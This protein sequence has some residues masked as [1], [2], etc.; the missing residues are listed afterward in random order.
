[1]N[2]FGILF[3]KGWAQRIII[4]G[5]IILYLYLG[6][7]K[8]E[9]AKK[10]ITGAGKTFASL[11]TLIFAALLISRAI[12]LLLPMETVMEWFGEDTG[13]KG[14]IRGGLLGGVLQGGPYAV[15][16][17]I[18]SIADKGAHISVVMAML[19]GYGAIGLARVAYGLVFF[20]AKIVGL[21]LLLAIPVPIVAGILV[22][23]LYD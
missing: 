23:L 8:P 14:I 22:Y 4:F 11:F 18:K 13:I 7:T 20:D 15:Y 5:A 3:G 9:V 2:W 1:M 16:P 6:V 10:G 19:M 12:G 21:R 17:I